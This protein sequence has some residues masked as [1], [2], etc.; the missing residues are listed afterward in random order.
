MTKKTIDDPRR[1]HWVAKANREHV[2]AAMPFAAL[3]DYYWAYS[4][5]NRHIRAA[6]CPLSKPLPD[7]N[8][9]KNNKNNVIK[10]HDSMLFDSGSVWKCMNAYGSDS[11]I[12]RAN[13]VNNFLHDSPITIDAKTVL[14]AIRGKVFKRFHIYFKKSIPD[15]VGL[16]ARSWNDATI[17]CV[18][19]K[20]GKDGV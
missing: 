4:T 20:V 8:T 10:P 9:A 12:G 18:F 13:H 15:M 17:R 16:T 7:G 11:Y 6:I 14:K 1:L 19:F 3:P 5:D 2:F